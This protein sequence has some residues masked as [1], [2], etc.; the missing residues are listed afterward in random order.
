MNLDLGLLAQARTAVAAKPRKF[1]TPEI[2]L[3]FVYQES[4]GVPYFIDHKPG[5]LCYA[6]IYS[7]VGYKRTLKKD[8][9]T[10]QVIRVFTGL[11]A[12]QITKEITLPEKVGNFTVPKVMRGQ[13]S[14]FRFEPGYFIKHKKRYPQLSLIDLFL[15][16]SSWGLVQ[17][18][19]PNIVKSPTPENL[20]FIRRFRADPAMQLLY[21]SGMID[22]LLVKTNG[23]VHHAYRGYNSGDVNST[24]ADTNERADNVMKLLKSIKGQIK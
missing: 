18:M 17:F 14:K 5:S 23:N 24:R 11:T 8:D 3:A 7:A 19:G 15:Y 4:G 10:K 6:N 2:L 9:G 20:E 16:S 1:L 13:L 21:G 22:D 12:M